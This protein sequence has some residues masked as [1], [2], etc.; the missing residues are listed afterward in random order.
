M[1]TV[2]GAIVGALVGAIVA[3]GAF[4]GYAQPFAWPYVAPHLVQNQKL[5]KK[6]AKLEKELTDLQE[7]IKKA[8]PKGMGKTSH[9]KPVVQVSNN[10]Q[11]EKQ[12]LLLRLIRAKLSLDLGNRN[13]GQ[14]LGQEA[15]QKG[16]TLATISP[17]LKEMLEKTETAFQKNDFSAVDHLA[18]AIV[19]LDNSLGGES[20][21]SPATTEPENEKQ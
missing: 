9:S 12:L 20:D 8:H 18:Y 17:E 11:Q 5:E 4:V 21:I 1:K 13:E 7:K 10:D 14:R 3:L 16:K 2:V 6:V 19:L 15:V